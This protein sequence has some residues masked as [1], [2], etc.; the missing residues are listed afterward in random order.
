MRQG[1]PQPHP[2]PHSPPMPWRRPQEGRGHLRHSPSRRI[3]RNCTPMANDFSS[4]FTTL[5]RK[6]GSQQPEDSGLCLDSVRGSQPQSMP[7]P[8]LEWP[9]SHL[10][11]WSAPV[12]CIGGSHSMIAGPAACMPIP[13]N[14]LEMRIL[15]PY[16]KPKNQVTGGGVQP[17]VL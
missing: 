12:V 6:V 5:K 14:S 15:L 8:T 16:L 13:R 7:E 4:W 3:S 17:S 11:G 9:H 1:F 10:A 2:A